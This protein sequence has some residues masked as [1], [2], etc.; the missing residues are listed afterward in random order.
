MPDAQPDCEGSMK[1]LFSV[2][3]EV[4]QLTQKRLRVIQ[5]LDANSG[6]SRWQC[7]GCG[8]AQQ[9]YWLVGFR[10]DTGGVCECV[11]RKKPDI[12]KD[13]GELITE[14]KLPIK[15]PVMDVILEEG[16]IDG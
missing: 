1:N 13:F 9:R 4:I 7:I 11:L 16:G 8:K 2:G 3:E 10:G 14:L 5:S 6:T 15:T 12:G